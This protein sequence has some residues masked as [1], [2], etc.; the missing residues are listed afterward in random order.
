MPE[1]QKTEELKKIRDEILALKESPLYEYRTDNKYFPVIGE[2]SHDAHLMFVGEAP[3]ENEAKTARPFCG[4]AGKVLDRLLESIGM[5]RKSVYVTNLVKDRPPGNRDP[6][7]AEIA[8]YGPFLDR[9]IALMKPRVIATLGRHSM[10]YIFEKYGLGA[11]LQ[12]VS[13][14]HGKEF[15]GTA[16]YGEVTVVALYHPAVAL[17]N[18]SMLEDMTEDFKILKK[19]I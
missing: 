10:K 4:R 11:V 3:G 13:K 16:P 17:Y 19:Y 15:K 8:L 6:E 2:G 14:I 9:Q 12:P 7:P 5:D 18:G 1:N